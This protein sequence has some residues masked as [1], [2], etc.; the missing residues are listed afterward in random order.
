[1]RPLSWDARWFDAELTGLGGRSWTSFPPGVRDELLAE[2]LQKPC[3]ECRA[4]ANVTCT[5]F[6]TVCWDRLGACWEQQPPEYRR[7]LLVRLKLQ[8]SGR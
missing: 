4:A 5:G 1:M 2:A 6:T 8:E 7:A 3:I